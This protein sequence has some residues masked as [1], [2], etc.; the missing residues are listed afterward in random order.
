LLSDH[1]EVLLP[2]VREVKANRIG[3]T[4]QIIRWGRNECI[5]ALAHDSAVDSFANGISA[6]GAPLKDEFTP[7]VQSNETHSCVLS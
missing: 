4:V 5:K 2:H 1:G 6:R 3:L 7:Y